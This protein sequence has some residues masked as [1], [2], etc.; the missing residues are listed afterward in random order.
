MADLTESPLQQGIAAL[1]AILGQGDASGLLKPVKARH[2]EAAAFCFPL[3]EDYAGVARKLHIGFPSTFPAEPL[4]LYVE[5]S[6]WLVWPHA[7]KS[8][9]C[10]HGFKERPVTGTPEVI[11]RDSLSRLSGILSLSLMNSDPELRKREFQNEIASY[12]SRQHSKSLQGLILLERPQTASELFALSDPRY[13]LPSG[14][15]TVWLSS[16]PDVIKNHFRRVIGRSVKARQLSAAGYYVKLQCY[17]DTTFPEPKDLMNWLLP[18]VTTEAADTLSE[19]LERT[20]S[21]ISR[22]I[23]LEMPGGSDAPTYTLNLYARQDNRDRSPRFNLRSSRRKQARATGDAPASI[24]SATLNILDNRDIYSRDLSQEIRGLKDAHVIFIGVGSLGGTV[25]SQLAR[26]GLRRLTLIDPDI[27]ESAN[28]GR[29]VLGADDLGK[30]KVQALRHRL[31]QDLPVVDITAINIHAQFVMEQRPEIFEDADL[32][33]IT[34][35]DWASEV[36]VWTKKSQGTRWGLL[37]GW[38]E[39]HTLTGQALIAP[40]GAYDGRHLFS[41]TGVFIH[42]FTEWPAGGAI[43]LPACGESFIPGG[44]VGM[45]SIATMVTQAAIRYLNGHYAA[46]AWM[47]SIY[48]PQDV[49]LNGGKYMGPDLPPGTVQSVL[50]RQWPDPGDIS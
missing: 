22:W 9:L 33:I 14:Q 36:A 45:T 24:R 17:P 16:S 5:P 43:P 10:L 6:P 48:R 39:P 32:V 20:G 8:G 28:L 3:P 35:A 42:R 25:V 46:P 50:E 30:P 11:V 26:A 31:I 41:D 47:T 7:I 49:Q 38:S 37:Q 44:S 18:N 4:R 2:G 21:L 13:R 40:Q 12:W 34:T 29:H 19:W 1:Q 23:I 27:L 15:E